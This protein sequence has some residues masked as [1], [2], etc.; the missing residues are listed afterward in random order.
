MKKFSYISLVLAFVALL[1]MSSCNDFLDTTPDTRVYLS[2]VDQLRDLLVTGYSTTNYATVCELSS[3]NVID[4]NA[5]AADGTRKNLSAYSQ[6]DDQL[7]AFEDVNTSIDN[8]SPSGIWSG[9]YHAIATANAV[10]EKAEEFKTK[11]ADA[12]GQLDNTTKAKLDAVMG[13]AY[14]IRAYHHFILCNVFCLPYR[15]P[16]LSKSI[17]G[18][19]YI[20]IPENEV[21]PTYE[22]GTLA[23]DYA[24]MEAD[25]ENGLKLVS[26]EFYTSPKYHFN[27]AA[28]NAFAARFYLFTRNYPKVVE[29]A[30]AAFK[31]NDPAKICS[32]IWA[33]TDFYYISDIGRY[34]TSVER[35]NNMLIMSS[36]SKWW[37]RFVQ[38]SRYA[39][40]G[41][42]K[43]ATIQGP[44]P[45]WE[46]FA[47]TNNATGEKFS[48]NPCFQGTLGTAGGSDYGAYF[49]GT[50]FE[51]F[52]FTDKLA[53]IGYVH[54]VRS[55]FNTEETLLCR[56]EAY[57]FLGEIDKALEDLKAYD[58]SMQTNAETTPDRY[59]PM[60]RTLVE[61][62]YSLE[63]SPNS[64]GRQYGIMKDI[65]LDDVCPSASYRVTAEILPYLQCVQHF[66]RIWTVHTG[67][68]W[69]D[70][71][72]LG[73][74]VTHQVGVSGAKSVGVSQ[75]DDN[76][77]YMDP[78]Y[79][80]QIPAEIIAAGL[81]A[82]P[83]EPLKLTA[84]PEATVI[85]T[86]V[87]D[88]KD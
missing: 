39:C 77:W 66:R 42:A 5:P 50:C 47:Y 10:L 22:R 57:L 7:F 3:D 87:P 48:M 23:D 1:P 9:C 84:L 52:E 29:H 2:T 13:E 85:T 83:R 67:M 46:G 44:G 81:K 8:D 20:T 15:G 17:D 69:F 45:S 68:R 43:R 60:T 21:N 53:G 79:A 11:G 70:I 14:L 32:D 38:S 73:L 64:G 31:G 25:L 63:G 78:H 36:Y 24:K 18:I 59:K 56:A 16:E 82:T 27:K 51:Q 28:A 76:A 61:K 58:A 49:A 40:N 33:K 86:I 55:E 19:P 26:D 72:R 12:N 30:T 54:G 6:A 62:F 4:N 34:F 37:R 65:H 75:G 74:S 80:I 88:N 41:N 35:A 71:K